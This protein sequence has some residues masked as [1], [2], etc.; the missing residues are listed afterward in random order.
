M[1]KILYAHPEKQKNI[2]TFNLSFSQVVNTVQIRKT[3]TFPDWR[4]PA[5]L[6][7][8]IKKPLQFYKIL[9]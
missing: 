5:Y 1:N 9:E 8:Q 2:I 3:G 6:H 4:K 7:H